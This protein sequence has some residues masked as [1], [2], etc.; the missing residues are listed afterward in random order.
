[1]SDSIRTDS[2]VVLPLV[3]V[4]ALIGWGTW[5]SVTTLRSMRPD[6]SEGPAGLGARDQRFAARLWQDPFNPTGGG[7]DRGGKDA[8]AVPDRF[9][10]PDRPSGTAL[11]LPVITQGGPYAEAS[12]RRL[13]DRYAVVAALLRAGYVPADPEYLG[14]ML[15]EVPAETTNA[16]ATGDGPA[17]EEKP[18]KSITVPFE[19][20]QRA[21]PATDE[22]GPVRQPRYSEILVLW[23]ASDAVESGDLERQLSTIFHAI[24]WFREGDLE[25]WFAKV[26]RALPWLEEADFGDLEV[27]CAKFLRAIPWFGAGTPVAIIGPWS[28]DGLVRLLRRAEAAGAPPRF[29]FFV[30]SATISAPDLIKAGVRPEI[31]GQW[32]RRLTATDDRLAGELVRE[33]CFRR[34]LPADSTSAIITVSEADTSYG[35]ALPHAFERA[36]PPGSVLRPYT[37]LRGVD[38]I[39]SGESTAARGSTGDGTKDAAKAVDPLARSEDIPRGTSQYDY[40]RRLVDRVEADMASQRRRVGAVGIFATDVYDKLLILQ[41]MR[42]RFPGVVFFTTDL[43]ARLLMPSQYR[44]T[45]NLVVASGYDLQ[46]GE[47]LQGP[48]PPF[49]DSYQTSMFLSVL[50]ATG[51]VE[52]VPSEGE[53]PVRVFEIGRTMARDLTAGVPCRADLV[54]V[55]PTDLRGRFPDAKPGLAY[56]AA[57]LLVFM[58]VF[59]RIN[60]RVAASKEAEAATEASSAPS[61]SHSAPVHWLTHASRWLR[62]HDWTRALLTTF[63][64]LLILGAIIGFLVI[65]TQF[66]EPVTMGGEPFALFEGISAWPTEGLRLLALALSVVY[67]LMLLVQWE[68]DTLRI[69]TRYHVQG[70]PRRKVRRKSRSIKYSVRLARWRTARATPPGGFVRTA[71]TFV[72]LDAARTRRRVGPI[73][74]WIMTRASRPKQV[75]ADCLALWRKARHI[76]RWASRPKQVWGDCLALWRKARHIL[77]LRSIM[78]WAPRYKPMRARRLWREYTLRASL[79]ARV[80]RTILATLVYVAFGVC[81]FTAFPM[82]PKPI[83]GPWAAW[84][85]HRLIIAAAVASSFLILLIWDATRLAIRFIRAVA[86]SEKTIYPSRSVAEG[87]AEGLDGESSSPLLDIDFIAHLTEALGQAYRYPAIVLFLMIVARAPLFDHWGIGAPLIAIMVIGFGITLATA[88]V[89]RLAAREAR[90]AEVERLRNRIGALRGL[91]AGVCDVK[92]DGKMK[93]PP[94][95]AEADRR[96]RA[97]IAGVEA[98]IVRI[99]S[100]RRGAFSNLREDPILG[101]LLIPLGGGAVVLLMQW[102]AHYLT[103]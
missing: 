31:D 21:V 56:A 73:V 34:A 37:Y 72:C 62:R 75:W 70:A 74:T 78:N 29:R 81:L 66:V 46:L 16:N 71:A 99:E 52:G 48:I 22:A 19:R 18:P 84:L 40:I 54:P 93:R 88:W 76:M 83:R 89:L 57:A 95:D 1:M 36:L 49:R 5:S 20:F 35:R 85:D 59:G 53:L 97:N 8:S 87:L 51:A 77:R 12:E 24:P 3:L 25:V 30:S 9:C 44:W 23:L 6:T 80:V 10:P 79:P 45:H 61:G 96:I 94:R 82:P 67:V 32:L 42:S 90:D 60:A 41:A 38:G 55:Q 103:A 14:Q 86:A 63:I 101:S 43:D 4:L 27:R 33:L 11:V 64:V 58:L 39:G 92:V 68:E 28:S 100:M 47:A 69:G 2:S 15:V 7:T 13:R 17:S 26:L 102:T 98:A 91:R 50:A 65:I